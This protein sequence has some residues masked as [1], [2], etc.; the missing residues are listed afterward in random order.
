[1]QCLDG[2]L[3]FALLSPQAKREKGT[4]TPHTRQGRH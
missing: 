1:M 2:A 4:D 3:L